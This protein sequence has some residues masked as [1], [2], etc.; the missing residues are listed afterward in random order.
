MGHNAANG[1][2]MRHWARGHNV[3]LTGECKVM[4]ERCVLRSWSSVAVEHIH[5]PAYRFSTTRY[6]ESPS[7]GVDAP[8]SEPYGFRTAFYA[9]AWIWSAEN[10]NL[11]RRWVNRSR[12]ALDRRRS[13]W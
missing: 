9:E 1:M 11:L 12:G 5:D 7:P 6:V 13:P 8:R 2:D 4:Q 3:S 10:S